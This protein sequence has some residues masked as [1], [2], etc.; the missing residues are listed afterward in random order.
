[1]GVDLSLAAE[2]EQGPGDADVELRAVGWVF[3]LRQG[4]GVELDRPAEGAFPIGL[5]S[6]LLARGCVLSFGEGSPEHGGGDHAAGG[7]LGHI[8]RHN[9]LLYIVLGVTRK[10]DGRIRNSEFE[11]RK[12]GAP[13]S[14][15]KTP[16]R[17]QNIELTTYHCGDT[18]TVC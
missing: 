6:R 2:G 15:G 13:R 8:P 3:G 4:L 10:V 12:T 11:I 16:V 18:A 5:Q 9:G 1:M 14:S 7:D 17:S